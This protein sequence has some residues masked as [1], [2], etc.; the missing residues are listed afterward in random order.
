MTSSKGTDGVRLN[1]FIASSGLCSRRR[2]DELI[3]SGRVK[4]DGKAVVELGTI[5]SPK[6]IVTVDGK[7]IVQTKHKTYI[8]FNKPRL[9]I[10]SKYDEEGRT[11]VMELLP[12]ELQGLFPVGRL[13][14]DASGLLLFTDDGDLANRL[15][16]P[17]YETPKT[18]AFKC[19]PVAAREDAQMLLD[20]VE[21]EGG[22]VTRAD[23]AIARN[24]VLTVVI[25][26]GRYHHIK[27]MAEAIGKKVLW[28]KRIEYGKVKLGDLPPGQW[29]YLTNEEIE[30]LMEG[31]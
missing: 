1:R 31:R 18:Y 14:Y 24:G 21:F 29:R 8:A 3:G 28:L 23:K 2:A 17:R 27:R 30:G 15:M 10:T 13:D 11:T 16:H 5:I 6:S 7:R 20:G 19:E 9:V 12:D 25:H 4:V 26:E 22:L